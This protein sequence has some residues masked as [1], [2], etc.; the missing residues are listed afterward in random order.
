MDTENIGSTPSFVGS[1]D[2][3]GHDRV[4]GWL[5]LE[6]G[7]QSR[8]WVSV[9][10]NGVTMRGG[11]ADLY[12]EDLREAG[13]ADGCAGYDF[14]FAPGE[15]PQGCTIF[16]YGQ[17]GQRGEA[18]LLAERAL[19]EP[20]AV[21]WE[22]RRP[23]AP[24]ADPTGL[25]DGS[26]EMAAVDPQDGSVD[27]LSV[28]PMRG[29]AP[30]GI[31]G[32]DDRGTV[33]TVCV[34]VDVTDLLFYLYHHRHVSGIQRVQ[35]G[36][37]A[38]LLRNRNPA[39]TFRFCVTAHAM[40]GYGDVPAADMRYLMQEMRS[41]RITDFQEWQAYTGKLRD[42]D[43]KS[44]SPFETGDILLVMGAP[45][46]YPDYF[47]SVAE[48]KRRYGIRYM[49]ISYDMIPSYLPEH[50]D[51]PLVLAF[52]YAVAGMLHYAEHVFAI[53]QYSAGDFTKLAQR[54]GVPATPVS[55]IPMGGTLDYNETAQDRAALLSRSVD[56]SL[57]SFFRTHRLTEFVLCVGTV[58]SRKNHAYLYHVW[59][60][61]IEVH[62]DATPKLVLVGRYGWHIESFQRYLKISNN[63]G[64]RVVHLSGVSDR[65]L[66]ALYQR[67]LFTVFPSFYEGWGLPVGE[68]LYYGKVPVTSST[69]SLP[70][71]GLD[72]AVYVDPFNVDDGFRAIDELVSDRPK[73]Q[74]LE[75]RIRDEYQPLS[76]K[77]AA[78]G[79]LA[80][81]VGLALAPSETPPSHLPHLDYAATYDFGTGSANR[82]T[83]EAEDTIRA[84]ILSFTMRDILDGEDWHGSEHWGCWASG[85]TARLAFCVDPAQQKPALAYVAVCL[86]PWYPDS[87]CQIS[88]PGSASRRELIRA[89]TRGR[90][91][92]IPI[93]PDADFGGRV[94]I[95]L[96]LDRLVAQ[97][98][99]SGNRLL[100]LGVYSVFVCYQDDFEARLTYLE[101]RI[102]A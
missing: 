22:E 65:E 15:L 2:Y 16:V 79:F 70:E 26:D 34:H 29:A 4:Y 6:G 91:F 64:G 56:R 18:V 10:V 11:V 54:C 24:W 102:S 39:V 61:L 78:D 59:K 9:V 89:G 30:F 46:V 96:S 31:S 94:Q 80:Q 5:A 74:A 20:P 52:N 57:D 48:V 101:D 17:A 55:V 43:S 82:D 72:F 97:P 58:E 81:I 27:V 99:D 53:S 68:S 33:H 21:E 77:E 25:G 42:Y 41:P 84:Q 76:W 60:R 8:A 36:Y 93:D 50:C 37:I 86:P 66:Q 85:D 14:V 71:V 67:A 69:T 62:G 88:T 19:D 75:Q 90:H 13:V 45:W 98:A 28:P 44:P 63:L 87:I 92:R 35:C 23:D 95:S 40:N 1:V 32:A 100:G 12:R 83:V 47:Y 51:T 49:Q 7:A 73:L 3:L 38:N